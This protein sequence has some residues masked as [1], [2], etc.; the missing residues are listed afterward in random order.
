MSELDD[1]IGGMSVVS[2][3]SD[4]AAAVDSDVRRAFPTVDDRARRADQQV[5]LFRHVDS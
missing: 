3:Q 2:V 1:L 5:E 4:D